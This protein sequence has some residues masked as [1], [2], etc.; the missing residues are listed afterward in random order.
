MNAASCVCDMGLTS[1]QDK[2]LTPDYCSQRE[3][4]KEL[5]AD[6]EDILEA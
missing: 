3:G 2:R 6:L 4:R 1:M 5:L